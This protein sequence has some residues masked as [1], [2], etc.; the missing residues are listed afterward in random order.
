MATAVKSLRKK[1]TN[2]AIAPGAID[3]FKPRQKAAIN[4]ESRFNHFRW[5]RQTGKST[6]AAFRRI[7]RGLRRKRNQI[8][9]SASAAQSRELMGKV[10]THLKAMNLI[11]EATE[12]DHPNPLDGM[13]YKVMEI[14]LP[15][16]LGG[17]RFIGLSSNPD[18]AR[19]YTGDVTLDEFAIH[20][21]HREI[22]A[23]V[24]PIVTRNDGELDVWSTPKGKNN[25]FYTLESNKLFTHDVQ[26]I[27]DAIADG[28]DL[29]AEALRQGIGD[30]DLWDQEYGCKYIDEAFAFLPYDLILPCEDEKLPRELDV[31]ALS[32][33]TN[34][35]YVGVDVA[36]TKN[37]T[38][39]WAF[40]SIGSMLIS[41]GLIEL[42]GKSFD[43]QRAV[44]WPI[45]SMRNMHR[46][47][48]DATGLGMDM[49]EGAVKKFGDWAVEACTFTPKFK[50]TAAGRMRV[51]FDDRIIRIPPCEIIRNDLHSV[52]KT[53]T[54]A[55]NI[56]LFAPVEGGSHADRF[57]ACALA[58]H[59]ASDPPPKI[60]GI[61]GDPLVN[62]GWGDF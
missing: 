23:A 45:L 18:T 47:A 32:R 8:L 51:R 36:R 25:T 5:S 26:T 6:T 58:C 12:S 62:D 21:D 16:S 55:G 38:V 39:I 17:I 28:H 29:D 14:T 59:A 7:V 34:S 33:C 30:S 20:K 61:F 22:W 57:W 50:D 24:F 37:F 11:F 43:D 60:E 2:P 3:F 31:E 1:S 10:K 56:R 4:K 42:Q 53:V 54:T 27:Y 52:L 40:E 19:G 49:A 48:I 35:F 46:C 9:M 13:T 41:R 44:L 15:E